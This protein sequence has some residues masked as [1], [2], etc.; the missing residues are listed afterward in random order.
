VD[1]AK[2]VERDVKDLTVSRN[3]S[4]RVDKV[5][6]ERKLERKELEVKQ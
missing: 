6:K 1:N 5:E 3:S 4:V 2:A